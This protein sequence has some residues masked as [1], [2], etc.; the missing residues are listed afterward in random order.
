MQAKSK[1]I[2]I[3]AILSSHTKS[4]AEARAKRD[5][6]RKEFDD[7]QARSPR[8]LFRSLD[9]VLGSWG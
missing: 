8:G 4:E 5:A 3:K 2:E 1:N 9:S 7:A 6:F